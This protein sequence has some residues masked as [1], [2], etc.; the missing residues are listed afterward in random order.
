MALAPEASDQRHQ[1][2]KMK[3]QPWQVPRQALFALS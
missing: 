3:D 2:S 1:N